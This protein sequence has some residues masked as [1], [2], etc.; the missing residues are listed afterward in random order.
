VAL[1]GQVGASLRL[2]SLRRVSERATDSVSVLA[3]L[4]QNDFSSVESPNGIGWKEWIEED[5]TFVRYEGTHA[6]A[7]GTRARMWACVLVSDR[8]CTHA[9]GRLCKQASGRTEWRTAWV[10]SGRWRRRSDGSAWAR[11]KRAS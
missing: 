8:A 1:P 2:A 4:L 6:H 3:L 9:C 11:S 10:S 5:G 7:Q